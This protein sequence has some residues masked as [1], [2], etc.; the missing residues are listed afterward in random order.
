MMCTH[1]I[2]KVV[3]VILGKN[4]QKKNDIVLSELV[5]TVTLPDI[6]EQQNCEFSFMSCFLII[7]QKFCRKA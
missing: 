1:A 4:I 2:A 5:C 3:K 6:S 7:Q